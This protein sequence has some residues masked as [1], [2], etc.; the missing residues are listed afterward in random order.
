MTQ[1]KHRGPKIARFYG[2]LIHKQK[3]KTYKLVNKRRILFCFSY[4][5]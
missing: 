3:V 5:F 2:R 1:I 4:N